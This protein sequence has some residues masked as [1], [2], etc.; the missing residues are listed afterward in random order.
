MVE[1]ADV[2]E[3][4]RAPI[5]RHW[6]RVDRGR[7]QDSGQSI[8][9]TAAWAQQRSAHSSP[10]RHGHIVR[11]RNARPSDSGRVHPGPPSVRDS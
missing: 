4:G 10:R 3:A 9:Q 8:A 1:G 2:V 11:A 7:P 6:S 5:G